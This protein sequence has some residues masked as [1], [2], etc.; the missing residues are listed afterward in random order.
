M[1]PMTTSTT[2][3]IRGDRV[4]RVVTLPNGQRRSMSLH[5]PSFADSAMDADALYDLAWLTSKTMP[6]LL[7]LQG[8]N[9]ILDLFCGYCDG[10]RKVTFALDRGFCT[11][12]A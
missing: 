11:M 2:Y 8:E 6:Q 4:S 5:V 7:D 3:A 10:V 9:R 12:S 1:Q